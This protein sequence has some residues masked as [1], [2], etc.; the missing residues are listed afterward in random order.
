M[1]KQDVRF[2]LRKRKCKKKIVLSVKQG[3][4]YIFFKGKI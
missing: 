1:E 2:P 3:K 4:V